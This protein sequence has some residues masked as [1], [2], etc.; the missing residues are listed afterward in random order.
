MRAQVSRWVLKARPRVTSAW[1][2]ACVA[3][4]LWGCGA[5]TPDGDNPDLT[6]TTADT[7]TTDADDAPTDQDVDPTLCGGLPCEGGCCDGVCLNLQVSATNCGAC[8]RVCAAGEPCVNGECFSPCDRPERLCD[9]QCVDTAR[10]PAH[11]GGC[12]QACLDSQVCF[13][14]ACHA[15][16]EGEDKPCLGTCANLQTDLKHCGLCGRACRDGERCAD[17]ACACEDGRRDCNGDPFDGCEVLGES[18]ACAP[19]AQRTCYTGSAETRFTGACRDGIQTCAPDASGWSAC[20]GEVRPEPEVCGDNLDNDCDNQI[21]EDEDLDGDGWGICSGDCCDNIAAGCASDPKRVNPGAIDFIG[22]NVDDDCDGQRDN[23]PLPDCSAAALFSGVTPVDLARAMGLC[24]FA[25]VPGQW[26][27]LS[28]T[29]HLADGTS[30]PDPR[31]VAVLQALGSE[32]LVTAQQGAT[33]AALSSGAARGVGDPGYVAPLP[34]LS[35]FTTNNTTDA[36]APFLAA[37]GGTLLTNPACPAGESRVNDPVMLRVRLR[38]PT[39]AQG[40]SFRFRFFSSEYPTWLCSAFN[41]FFVVLLHSAHP[42]IAADKNISFDA[43][44][45]P[46][47]VN[48]AFFTTCQ[49]Q[50][51]G[52]PRSGRDV[53]PLDGC[54]D[55]LACDPNLNLCVSPLGACPDGSAAVR[56]YVAD[57]NQAGATSWLTTQAPVLP[58]EEVTLEF[59]IWDTSDRFLDSLVL[60]D[61]FEWR[62]DPTVNLTFN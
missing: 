31:Q 49:S 51:C 4:A 41:D 36:P 62:I 44:G 10:A 25:D 30:A 22:N 16:C 52:Y 9:N 37:N 60:I 21:D 34:Q 54:P 50:V 59:L 27:V 26:G 2:V 11:C 14:S 42:G 39:N 56:A 28:A 53:Q 18:C 35:S 8:G 33:M 23:P 45:N 40:L 17:G 1:F 20:V 24:Q 6:T 57:P 7:A 29:L 19:N 61:S 58:G 46:V 38:A 55:S 3:M 32:R 15:S 43:T 12:G 47:S 48:N 5:T 13:G